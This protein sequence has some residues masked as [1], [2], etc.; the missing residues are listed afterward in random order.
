MAAVDNHKNILGRG[1]APVKKQAE[2]L[3]AQDALIKLKLSS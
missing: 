2:Q 1:R 3:A